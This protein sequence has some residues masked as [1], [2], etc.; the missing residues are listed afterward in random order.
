MTIKIIVETGDV[1]FGE[2]FASIVRQMSQHYPRG[3]T[4][5]EYMDAT[6]RRVRIWDE[7]QIR[8]N[9]PEEFIW[10]LHRVGV[11]TEILEF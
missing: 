1:Y 10:E 6:A 9:T 3:E 4:K 11:I 5:R 8:T 2:T 7:V